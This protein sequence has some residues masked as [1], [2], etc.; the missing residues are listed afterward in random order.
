M[1]QCGLARSEEPGLWGW[2]GTRHVEITL[3]RMNVLYLG[4][5]I[6]AAI[7]EWNKAYFPVI[8]FFPERD[9][10]N[11]PVYNTRSPTPTSV[12]R[13]GFLPL[14]LFPSQASTR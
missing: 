4:L 11:L 3:P 10:G 5:E 9:N 7:E 13:R 2:S 12:V 14:L 1:K 8:F 6:N